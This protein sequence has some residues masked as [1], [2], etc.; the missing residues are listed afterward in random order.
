MATV[1]DSPSVKPQGITSLPL[2][3]S[4]QTE[5]P[6]TP[7]TP[8][9]DAETGLDWIL[10]RLCIAYGLL[11]VGTHIFELVHLMLGRFL[12]PRVRATPLSHP[13]S[14]LH[15]GAEFQAQKPGRLLRS[16]PRGE[17]ET[18]VDA[19]RPLPRSA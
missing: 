2:L 18:P 8:S 19:A 16:D 15:E 13:P 17:A 1:L 5:F 11:L 6:E 12:S 10:I 4:A 14:P 3:K 7:K 9:E